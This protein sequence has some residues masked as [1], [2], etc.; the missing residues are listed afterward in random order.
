VIERLERKTPEDG[1]TVAISRA[2]AKTWAL[3]SVKLGPTSP[4]ETAWACRCPAEKMFVKAS[5]NATVTGLERLRKT[6]TNI[7]SAFVQLGTS[8]GNAPD[9]Y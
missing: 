1:S 7:P 4:A 5:R 9:S 2:P 3:D 8:C 6:D